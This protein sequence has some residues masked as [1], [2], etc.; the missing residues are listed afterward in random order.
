MLAAA[1]LS[2]ALKFACELLLAPTLLAVLLGAVAATT[3]LALTPNPAARELGAMGLRLVTVT[4]I[5]LVAIT[6]IPHASQFLHQRAVIQDTYRESTAGLVAA[7]ERLETIHRETAA[8][9]AA[10]DAGAGE[11][12][13]LFGRL[14]DTVSGLTR[15]ASELFSADALYRQAARAKAAADAVS[16]DIISQITLF[17]LEVAL[18]PLVVL[19]VMTRWLGAQLRG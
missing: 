19:Y 12:P 8:P 16:R 5:V 14:G 2:L 11:E 3:A 7:Q 4:L 10:G 9:A 1:A 18:V 13:G 17:L 6:A 15:G